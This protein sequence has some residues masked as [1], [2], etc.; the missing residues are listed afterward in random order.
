MLSKRD[1]PKGLKGHR[2]MMARILGWMTN[3]IS[4]D[5]FDT[6]ARADFWGGRLGSGLGE[7]DFILSLNQPHLQLLKMLQ[8]M[9]MVASADRDGLIWYKAAPRAEWR[10]PH[11]IEQEIQASR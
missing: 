9:G 10:R 3:E 6:L 1:L 5:Q 4:Q 7:D 8:A 2:D 11:E